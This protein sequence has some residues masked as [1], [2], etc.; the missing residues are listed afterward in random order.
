LALTIYQFFSQPINSLN[1]FN[2]IRFEGF[3]LRPAARSLTWNGRAIVLRS[4]TFDLLLYLAQHP[5]QVVA[6]EELMAALWP[7]SFVEESNLAQHVFLLRK[8]LAENGQGERIV[9]TVPGKGYQ[10]TAPLDTLPFFEDRPGTGELRI[11][12][13]QSVTRMVIEAEEEDEP[14]RLASLPSPSSHSRSWIWIAVSVGFAV[15]AVGSILGWKKLHSRPSLRISTFTRITHD[16]RPKSFGG[17]DESRIYFEWEDTGGIAEISV[18]GGAVEPI[19]VA[20]EHP[21]IGEV[22]PDGSTLLFTSEGGGKGPA[23]SLWTLPVLGGSP[24]RLGNAVSSTWSP[25]G[26]KVA[27]GTAS[28]DICILRRDGSEAHRIASVG[29]YLKSLAWSPDGSVIRFSRDGLLWEISTAGANLHQL[30]PGWVKSP[31][32][33]SGNWAKDGQFFFVADGQLWLLDERHG[34]GGSLPGQPVQLTFGP[35]VWDHPIPSQDGKKIFASARTKRG[36]LVHFDAR[37]GQFQPFL[38]GISAEFVSFSNDG[39]SVAYVSYPEGVLWRANSDGRDPLQLTEPPVYPKSARWSPDGSRIAFVDRTEQGTDAIYVV[40]SDGSGKPQRLLPDDR[41]AETDPSWSPDA[42]KIAFSTSP[43]VGASAKSD[44]RILDL[45]SSQVAA[46]P[47]SDGLVV[48]HW[49]PDGASIAA[50]TLDTMSMRLFNI[51]TGQWTTLNTGAVAFPEWSHDS[52]SIYYVRWTDEPAVLRIR[53]ADGRRE[54]MA[55]LK[56]RQYTGV[57]TMWMG[58]DPADIPMMLRD[59]GTDDIYSLAM[60]SK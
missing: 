5:H 4:K 35:T 47:G 27:Y 1:A 41:R 52:R 40:A 15:L 54:S 37:S 42:S 24:R 57:Y 19:Q 33:W 7:D 59:A 13:V 60:E 31:T 25:D 10:F 2:L 8:A 45:A 39:K 50:M 36:E 34:R 30:L 49:S 16:G 51:S 12:A 28:G 3:E 23:D 17:T 58:L 43:N 6:K 53:V 32:E 26:T 20:L 14:P 38:A 21:R 46:I 48:P 9:V 56:G 44:L 22:S 29:G 18:S 11:S 55:D